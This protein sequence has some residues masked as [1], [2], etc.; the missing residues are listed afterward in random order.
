[1][2][3][4]QAISS[5]AC[6]IVH[7]SSKDILSG[8]LIRLHDSGVQASLTA[9]VAVGTECLTT[10]CTN[11]GH[12]APEQAICTE[13]AYLG[14]LTEP[15]PAKSPILLSGKASELLSLF[16]VALALER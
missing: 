10:S 7:Y 13:N 11:Y 8:Q 9:V 15:A 3:M 16:P 14:H 5:E 4:K 6:L 12:S 2:I 1:M